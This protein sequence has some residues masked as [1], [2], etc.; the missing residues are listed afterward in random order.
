MT[1][2]KITINLDKDLIK[3]VNSEIYHK[4]EFKSLSQSLNFLFLILF[5]NRDIKELIFKKLKEKSKEVNK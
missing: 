5:E 1:K 4:N 3:F 2:D